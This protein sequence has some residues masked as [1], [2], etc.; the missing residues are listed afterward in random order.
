MR[1]EKVPRWNVFMRHHL[2]LAL[3]KMC[4]RR[5][6]HVAVHGK[7]RLALLGWQA[8]EPHCTGCGRCIG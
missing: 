6:R 2:Y 8:A 7:C 5:L 1:P 4:C 3:R